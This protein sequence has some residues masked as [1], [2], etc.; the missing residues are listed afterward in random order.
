MRCHESSSDPYIKENGW[1]GD[2]EY[3]SYA[4]QP[5]SGQ[6]DGRVY[7]DDDDMQ[8]YKI[9]DKQWGSQKK[10]EEWK[11]ENEKKE[12]KPDAPVPAPAKEPTAP[13]EEEPTP[14][15]KEEE[16]PAAKEEEPTP[17]AKEEP[18]PTA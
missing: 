4:R 18:T 8:M 17:D 1:S 15:A 12:E 2:H 5:R 10:D 11:Y 14:V 9:W 3:Y 7:H 13:A 16:T 6:F